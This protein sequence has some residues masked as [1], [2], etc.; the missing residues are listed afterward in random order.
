MPKFKIQDSDENV[1]RL[2]SL[3]PDSQQPPKD[4]WKTILQS[5]TNY[6]FIAG[7][8]LPADGVRPVKCS[9]LSQYSREIL[10]T[11]KRLSYVKNFLFLF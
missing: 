2:D 11:L 5:D 7:T 10:V 4:G 9:E 8:A 6:F 1:L 3:T